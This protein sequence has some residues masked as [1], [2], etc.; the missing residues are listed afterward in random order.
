MVHGDVFGAHM[1]HRFL[2]SSVTPLETG[3]MSLTAAFLKQVFKIEHA[4]QGA[5]L[6]RLGIRCTDSE[7]CIRRSQIAA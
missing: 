6:S 2:Q 7:L 1:H 5:L 4:L 3:A